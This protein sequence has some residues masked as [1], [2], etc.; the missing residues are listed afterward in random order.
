MIRAQ[1]FGICRGYEDADDLD[2]LR[3]DPA[4]KLACGRL[5]DSG[6]DLCSQPTLWRLENA[7]G[8]E[9][10][11]RLTYGRLTNGWRPAR[12]RRP[13][14]RSTSPNTCDAADGHQ[15]PSLFNAH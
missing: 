7:P 8:L 11:I 13:R 3:S 9:D 5:P 1:V 12:C 15:Q 10:A 4:F 2:V 14:S 6:R